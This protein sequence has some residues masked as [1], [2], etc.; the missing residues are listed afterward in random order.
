MYFFHTAARYENVSYKLVVPHL[1]G[2]NTQRQKILKSNVCHIFPVILFQT[3]HGKV[4]Y[5][6]VCSLYIQ[7]Q[8]CTAL[9]L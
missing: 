1:Y 5:I 6:H 8:M 3:D 9:A 7:L 4:R 2:Q